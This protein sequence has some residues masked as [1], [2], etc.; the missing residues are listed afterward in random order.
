VFAAIGVGAALLVE[1][2]WVIIRLLN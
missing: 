1:I 2:V